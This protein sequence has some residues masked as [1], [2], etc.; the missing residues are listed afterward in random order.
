MGAA[1]MGLFAA[2]LVTIAVRAATCTSRGV[3]AADAV[4]V[5]EAMAWACEWSVYAL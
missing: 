2:S 5:M 3:S 4:A 1:A